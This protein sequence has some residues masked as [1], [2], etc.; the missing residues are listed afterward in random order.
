LIYLQKSV[1]IVSIILHS[2]NQRCNYLQTILGI[3]FHSTSVPEKVIE[4]LSHAGISVALST[5]HNA[6]TSLSKDAANKLKAAARTLTT[7]FAYDNFDIKFKTS[8]PTVEHR[9]EFVS[10]TS[11][12]AIPLYGI[13][14]ANKD[15]LRWSTEFWH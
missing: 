8:Q 11:A 9:A 3:F 5:I 12:T 7:G 1:V 15:M 13:T 6:V 2:S 14:D 10:A 4:T